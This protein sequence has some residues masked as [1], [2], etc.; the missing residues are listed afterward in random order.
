MK[1]IVINADPKMRQTTAQLVKSAAEGAKS[2]G[3]D[4]EYIDLY[5]F[6]L[7]GCRACLICKKEGKSCRC[8]WKD[9]LSPLIDRILESDAL[10]IGVPIFFSNPTSHYLALLERLIFC[11]VSFKTGNEFK[12]K[13][14][15]G[16]F[17]TVEYP[18]DYFEN[19]VHPH[20]KQTEDL[21]KMLNGKL[22]V[23]TF[24]R[25]T[26]EDKSGN[27]DDENNSLNIK[28]EQLSKDLDNVFEIGADL[29]K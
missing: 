29:S 19:S 28:E 24:S 13:V 9:E 4:V 17:Y 27:S 14:N 11:I 20:L 21:L 5:R 26:K 3:A 15:V 10:L 8:Y 16:L 22:I 1:T 25:I 7:S 18:L 12:G 2:A 6:D 23:D